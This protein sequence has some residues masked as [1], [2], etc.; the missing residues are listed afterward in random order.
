MLTAGA[1][2]LRRNTTYKLSF[3]L[4]NPADS[5]QAPDVNVSGVVEIHPQRDAM[6]VHQVQPYDRLRVNRRTL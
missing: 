4:R 1:A 5:Q 6:G 2:G 3:W